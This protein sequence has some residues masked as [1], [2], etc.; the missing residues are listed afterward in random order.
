VCH[1]VTEAGGM[2]DDRLTTW[3]DHFDFLQ[4]RHTLFCTWLLWRY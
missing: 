3:S 4:V 2:A 1:V